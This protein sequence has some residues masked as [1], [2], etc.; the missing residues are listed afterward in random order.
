MPW[1]WY[2]L[3]VGGTSPT[4]RFGQDSVKQPANTSWTSVPACTLKCLLPGNGLLV[5]GPQDRTEPSGRPHWAGGW[6][7][8]LPSG[9]GPSAP[10]EGW[11]GSG[12]GWGFL[13]VELAHL[14]LCRGF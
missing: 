9:W 8:T 7:L 14:L 5:A 4:L 1:G 12:A 3:R 6:C 11:A 10:A 2:P 13:T